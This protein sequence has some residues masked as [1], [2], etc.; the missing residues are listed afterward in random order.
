MGSDPD[1]GRRLPEAPKKPLR[2]RALTPFLGSEAR[3]RMRT[4][5]YN[6]LLYPPPPA[7]PPGQSRVGRPAHPLRMRRQC[8]GLSSPRPVARRPA[9]AGAPGLRRSPRGRTSSTMSFVP[10]TVMCRPASSMRRKVNLHCR[11]TLLKT[12]RHPLF[13][14]SCFRFQP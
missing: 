12:Q 2:N 5:F 3:R 7:A 4:R 1:S 11:R 10:S 14:P 13:S 9:C 8:S 6:Q